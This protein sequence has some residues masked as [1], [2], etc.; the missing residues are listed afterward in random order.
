[1]TSNIDSGVPGRGFWCFKVFD[2]MGSRDIFPNNKLLDDFGCGVIDPNE[3]RFPADQDPHRLKLRRGNVA[4]DFSMKDTS[5]T[6]DLGDLTRPE[7]MP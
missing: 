6:L 1:M 4:A 3:V 2:G 7:Y 5:T